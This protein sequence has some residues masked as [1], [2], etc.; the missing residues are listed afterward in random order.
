MNILLVSH[1]VPYPLKDGGAIAL[2]NT[3]KGLYKEGH[4]ITLF[5]L[6]AD[7]HELNL[8]EAEKSIEEFCTPFFHPINTEVTVIGALKN[9]FNRES[10]NVSRFY[11]KEFES[12]LIAEAQKETYDVI[13]FETTFT[14]PYAPAL[15]EV[16]PHLPFILRQHNVESEIWNRRSTTEKNPLKR[17]YLKFLT[18]RLMQ[19]EEK[20]SSWFDGVIT[21]TES[22]KSSIQESGVRVPIE[23]IPPGFEFSED[24]VMENLHLRFF[25]IGSMKWEPNVDAVQW[26]ISSIWPKVHKVLP[27]S[28]FHFAGLGLNNTWEHAPKDGLIN[29]G[30]VD[31]LEDFMQDKSICVVPLKSGSGIRIKILECMAA[32]KLVMSTAI[33]A[34][35]I[36]MKSGNHFLEFKGEEDFLEHV[37]WINNNP[38]GA[39]E[40]ARNGQEYI[41]NHYGL[42]YVSKK[43]MDFYEKILQ[44]RERIK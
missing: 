41:R 31:S 1:R 35:G 11:D 4:H 28:T 22:D 23:A 10:Y 14:A 17:W 18:S 40:I 42:T 6:A 8:S 39:L 13:Q 29:A 25:H 38:T 16:S 9:L 33:G 5:A 36:E 15:R 7:K 27:E 12:T 24:T 19:Y 43:T 2:Y 21:L 20:S 30:E 34:Q 44:R 32:G 37:D 3:I 26:F